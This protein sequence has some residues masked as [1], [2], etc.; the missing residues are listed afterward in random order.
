MSLVPDLVLTPKFKMPEFEKYN[1]MKCLS[2]HLF[3]F[4]RKITSY[5]KNEMLLI[6]YFQD[7]QIG[8]A[9]L[10]YNQLDKNNIYSR[11]DLGKAFLTQY[12]YMTNSALDRMFFQNIKKKSNETFCEYVY[13]WRDLESQIQPHMTEKETAKLF[14]NTLKNPYYDGMVGN[15]TKIFTDI[16]IAREMI[17]S[18]VKSNKIKNVEMQKGLINK[19]NERETNVVTYRKQ[20][21]FLYQ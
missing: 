20:P 17:Q 6:H 8:S 15:I 13:R 7:S 9:T 1:G 16:V 14:I 2:T 11:R 19:K 5:T 10:W 18:V 3:M 12:K 21:Y 4:C